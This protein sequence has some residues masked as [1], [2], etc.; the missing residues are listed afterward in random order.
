MIL[1]RVTLSN[2]FRNRAK[3]EP[4][5]LS[6]MWNNPVPYEGDITCPAAEMRFLIHDISFQSFTS[7]AK[8]SDSL[9]TYYR[10]RFKSLLVLG[11]NREI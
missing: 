3:W 5:S 2:P 1:T 6:E 8:M 4:S 9:V 11:R 7:R 10:N